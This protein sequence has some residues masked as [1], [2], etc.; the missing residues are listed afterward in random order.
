M[1]LGGACLFSI[2]F[3]GC[4]RDAG[5]DLAKD[6]ARTDNVIAERASESILRSRQE[7]ASAGGKSVKGGVATEELDERP[8]LASRWKAPFKSAGN[9][10]KR[11]SD[12][13][14]ID[15]FLANKS[16]VGTGESK[17]ALA[18]TSKDSTSTASKVAASTSKSVATA[19]GEK[20]VAM[21]DT[22]GKSSVTAAR[23]KT[24][25]STES[26]AALDDFLKAQEPIGVS[27]RALAASRD[28]E[29]ISR[30]PGTTTRPASSTKTAE[31]GIGAASVA[32][33]DSSGEG[34]GRTGVKNG[35]ARPFPGASGDAAAEQPKAVAAARKSTGGTSARNPLAAAPAGVRRNPLLDDAEE[36]E[37]TQAP[38]RT[39]QATGLEIASLLKKAK[40]AGE[41]GEFEQAISYATAASE[42]AEQ[43]SY[44]FSARE[45][46]PERIVAWLEAKQAAVVAEEPIATKA[47]RQHLAATR[48]PAREVA[49]STTSFAR[50][51]AEQ[52]FADDVAA[53][54]SGRDSSFQEWAAGVGK[55]P[56]A[57]GASPNWPTLSPRELA[58]SDE[59]WQ[60]SRAEFQQTWTDLRTNTAPKREKPA[61][62]TRLA[63]AESDAPAFVA[64]AQAER[65]GP[66]L[67]AA[68]SSDPIVQ[69][70][71]PTDLAPGA[72]VAVASSGR[73]GPRLSTP[74]PLS[75]ED[76]GAQ[77][78]KASSSRSAKHSRT[79]WFAVIGGLSVLVLVGFRR[80]AYRTQTVE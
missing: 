69:L 52:V 4:G 53:Q 80:W 10:M 27:D 28:S 59:L 5:L 17:D 33:D 78:A 56:N 23:P 36:P 38:A 60:P 47:E 14:I 32:L 68:R 9:L 26:Q 29:A 39:K 8:S 13:D 16:E 44:E 22:A 55:S 58:A 66:A 61:M 62:E 76:A 54:T 7:L 70:G 75:I 45:H 41:K 15:P 42:L 34:S 64:T 43:C 2:G 67:I 12:D 30:K 79:I 51:S 40:T 19:S 48:R 71:E 3:A 46:T 74:P 77:R 25:T 31:P 73:R 65:T 11:K 21:A 1:A 35:K 72:E 50:P 24:A 37:D 49:A 57:G 63:S 20:K 6:E 18:S